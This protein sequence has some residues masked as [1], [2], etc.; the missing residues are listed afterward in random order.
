MTLARWSL[1]LLAA[2]TARAEIIAADSTRGARLFETQ[3]CIECHGVNGKG[4]H[5]GPDLGR[6]V[7]RDYTPATLASL[8]WN[9]APAMW[10]AMRERGISPGGLKEQL[11]EQAAADLFAY[12]YSVR[13]F[14]KP[15]DAGRGKRLFEERHCAKCHGLTDVTMAPAK[16][17]S[18]WESL[19]S[20]IA[21]T[22]AM[23]NH[24]ANM[25]REMD[26]RKLG[27]I[28]LSAQDLTDILVYLRNL[29][30]TR[31][32]APVFRTTAGQGGK[33]IFLSSGCAGCHSSELPLAPRLRHETL[34]GIAAEMWNHEPMMGAR[35]APPP[36][37]DVERMRVLVSYL[38][39]RRFFEDS[40][41]PNRGKRVFA[42][43]K[44][45][46]CHDDPAGGAPS[47]A[48]RPGAFTGIAMATALWHHGP[49]MLNRFREK[50]L[51]WP[52]FDGTQM[53][54]LIAYL[55]MRDARGQNA[56]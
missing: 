53:P 8:L 17:V 6:S 26:L 13:F 51:S 54:D 47:L 22:A 49:A 15:G 35:H 42:A 12:F 45:S 37:L 44:C 1:I 18:Q 20:P 14:E 16:P 36:Q 27:W 11:N 4:G 38:W 40:G 19:D 3:G 10:T 5:V 29:P 55:N 43:K 34:T 28:R 46:A 50:N 25:S 24:A 23:W 21:L 32:I 30:S 2:A 39:A 31:E 52:R 41:D 56:K 33:E 48:Q 7:D 9:H